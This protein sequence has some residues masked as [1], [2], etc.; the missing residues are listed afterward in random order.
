VLTV[1]AQDPAVLDKPVTYVFALNDGRTAPPGSAIV[2]TGP[3]VAYI[4]GVL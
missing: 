3:A 2:D 1:N 4:V